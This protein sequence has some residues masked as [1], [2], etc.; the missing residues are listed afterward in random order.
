VPFRD[1]SRPFDKVFP[2]FVL[3]P[4]EVRGIR[5]K[6]APFTDLRELSF[7]PPRELRSPQRRRFPSCSPA[8]KTV[9]RS[10]PL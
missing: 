9:A 4:E 8:E 6:S 1:S 5:D 7:P 10:N 3:F 2:G